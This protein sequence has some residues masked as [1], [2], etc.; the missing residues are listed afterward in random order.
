MILAGC[1]GGCDCNNSVNAD[2]MVGRWRSELTPRVTF[3]FNSN[4]TGLVNDSINF[5]W[6]SENGRLTFV[7]LPDNFNNMIGWE[8]YGYDWSG[9]HDYRIM[10]IYGATSLRILFHDDIGGSPNFSRLGVN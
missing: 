5:T 1:S 10:T 8:A 3:Q 4:G 2:A 6:S 9:T 7:G